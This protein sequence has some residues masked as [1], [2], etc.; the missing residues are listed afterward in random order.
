MSTQIY[1]IFPGPL[2]K[3]ELPVYKKKEVASDLAL[4]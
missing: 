2:S 4:S 1:M 3:G